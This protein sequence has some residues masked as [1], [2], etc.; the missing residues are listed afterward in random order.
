MTMGMN[1]LGITAVAM[2][3][4]FLGD[5]VESSSAFR[6]KLVEKIG[7]SPRKIVHS[8]ELKSQ[9]ST[10]LRDNRDFSNWNRN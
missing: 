4:M 5:Y 7:K 2:V 6:G 8:I 10:F 1:H 9:L 3:L